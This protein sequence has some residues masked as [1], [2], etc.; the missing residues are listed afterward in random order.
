MECLNMT[1]TDSEILFVNAMRNGQTP[2]KRWAASRSSKGRIEIYKNKSIFLEHRLDEIDG[3]T[4]PILKMGLTV[5][6]RS[7]QSIIQT[8]IDDVN[9]YG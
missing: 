2:I 7:K 5:G 3:R 1:M 6:S 4:I 8:L 9:K